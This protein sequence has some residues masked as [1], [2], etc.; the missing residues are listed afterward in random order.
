MHDETCADVY[1]CTM[2]RKD[3]MGRKSIAEIYEEAVSNQKGA[4]AAHARVRAARMSVIC[5]G[6]VH[7]TCFSLHS[8][9][10]GVVSARACSMGSSPMCV[11]I[12]VRRCVCYAQAHPC[13][14]SRRTCWILATSSFSKTKK[15]RMIGERWESLGS[16][17]GN[18]RKAKGEALAT[19]RTTTTSSLIVKMMQRVGTK[20]A[21]SR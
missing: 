4:H 17:D 6:S 9:L 5:H 19:P 11:F 2:R 12:C 1:T 8:F 10:I 18:S 20:S 13:V 15:R 3:T 21:S 7:C 14:I 16:A